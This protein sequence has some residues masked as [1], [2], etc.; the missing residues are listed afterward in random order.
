MLKCVYHP[1]HTFQVVEDEEADKLIASGVWF[2]T[3]TKAKIYR[4]KVEEEI[5]QESKEVEKP[6]KTKKNRKKN[7]R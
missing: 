4:D 3:P 1:I 5:R 6:P 7:E 2:D